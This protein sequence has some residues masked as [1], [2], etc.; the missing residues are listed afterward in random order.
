MDMAKSFFATTYH[1]MIVA[2]NKWSNEPKIHEIIQQKSKGDNIFGKR[3]HIYE[4]K[5]MSHLVE[6]FKVRANHINMSAVAPR[7][8]VWQSLCL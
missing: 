7:Q 1:I 6:D 4:F 2:A 8:T 3:S 5:M